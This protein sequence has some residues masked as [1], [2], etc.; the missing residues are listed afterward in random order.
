MVTSLTNCLGCQ[1]RRKKIRAFFRRVFGRERAIRMS[2]GRTIVLPKG[3]P[4]LDYEAIVNQ[5]L[6]QPEQTANSQAVALMQAMQAMGQV[7]VVE[8]KDNE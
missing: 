5:I 4:D 7:Q 2:D 6:P 8:Q 3:A 1:R